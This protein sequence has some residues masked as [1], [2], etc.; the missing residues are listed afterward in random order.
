VRK[1]KT[2]SVIATLFCLLSCSDLKVSQKETTAANEIAGLYGGTCTYTKNVAASSK[3]GKTKSFE[4]EISNSD[5][6]NENIQFAEMFAS[7]MA[8]IFFTNVKPEKQKYDHIRSSIVYRNGSKA[9][10]DYSFDTLEL[11][12]KKMAYVNQVISLFNRDSA[13]KIIQELKPG[14]FK[15][16]KEKA[17]YFS[18]LKSADTTFGK[19]VGFTPTGFRFNTVGSGIS[20]LH[21]AGTVK[22]SI[23]D[24]QFSID[25][26]PTLGQ[27]EVYLFR[28]DY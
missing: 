6:L 27:D 21:I 17:V 11:V 14:V 13:E 24:T 28:Y 9:F 22:R 10:F 8:Y 16:E 18:K 20:I 2:F 1:I 12:T 3:Y 7:N 26:N 5:F 25:I 15:N 4:L 23:Q 19:I